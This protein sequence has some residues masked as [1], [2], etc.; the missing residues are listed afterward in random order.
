MNAPPW[1]SLLRINRGDEWRAGTEFTWL[2]NARLV[3]IFEQA[4]S[5]ERRRSQK[6]QPLKSSTPVEPL[7]IAD[8]VDF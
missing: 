8:I 7:I 2:R 1:L 6:K 4:G 5:R 3:G